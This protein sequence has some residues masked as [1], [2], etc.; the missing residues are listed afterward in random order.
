MFALVM[1]KDC[2]LGVPFGEELTSPYLGIWSCVFAAITVLIAIGFL[3][4]IDKG[5]RQFEGMANKYL[6]YAFGFVWMFG[7]VVYDIGMCMGDLRSLLT[8]APMAIIYAFK[9]FIFDSDISAI[10]A[11]LY[12]DWLFMAAYSLVHFLAAVVSLVF[13]L[14][15]FGFHIMAAFKRWFCAT[16]DV[17][18]IFW[19]MNDATYYLANDINQQT[20]CHRRRIVVV[21]TDGDSEE[22]TGRNGFERL[23]HFLSLKNLDLNRLKNLDCI[24]THCS[25]KISNVATEPHLHAPTADILRKELHLHSLCKLIS[26]KTNEVLHIFFLSE[27][28]A[29]NTQAVAALKKDATICQF[30][31]HG[32]RT[33]KFYCH[34]RYNSV[35]R[36]IEDELLAENIEVKVIDSSHINV[37]LLKRK[38]ELQPVSFVNIEKDATVSSPFHSLVVGFSEVGRDTVSFLY[39]FGA[40]VKSG[41]TNDEVERSDFQ[42]HVVDKDMAHLAGLFV[43]NTPAIQPAM[44]F[45]D[46]GESPK[47]LITLHHLDCLSVNF[48]QKLEGWIKDNLNY[49]VICTENDELN[50]SLAVRIFKL[51]IRYRETMENFCILVRV[52]HDDNGHIRRIAEHYN[53]LWAAELQ[54]IDK[55]KKTHQKT[56][57]VEAQIQMPIYLFGLDKDTYTYDNIISDKLEEEAKRY[58]AMY[59]ASINALKR[60]SGHKEETAPTWENEHKDL[61][62]LTE[63]YKGYSPTY[64]GITRLRRIQSQNMANCFHTQTKQKLAYKALGEKDY[65]VLAEYQLFRKENEITYSWKESAIP[66]NSIIRVLDVLA[67]TEHLRWNASHELLGYRNEGGEEHKDEAK[68]QHGCLKTWQ[69]LS[70]I[71]QSYDYNMVDVSLGIID[72]D[73]KNN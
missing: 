15:Y 57:S 24:T 2:L 52:H 11:S 68:L 41:S 56:V 6:L 5:W 37:E 20:G 45:M 34:A 3:C 35:H 59:D 62:Q 7:F 38:V 36:V 29:E 46:G 30:L 50:I 22:V 66:N 51:A 49:V 71:V 72:L 65:A 32:N 18:Y 25:A 48:Y 1:I 70:T 9:I 16:K 53:R 69:E 58:K 26:K 21:R 67:Q 31:A 33:V 12:D 17:T 54:S 63:E 64:S 23:F 61:M 39:E 14:K 4:G 47:S 55:K 28:E 42:C 10:R 44:P 8:N 60:Q 40:F 13:V 43:A 27:N 19:G 73:I